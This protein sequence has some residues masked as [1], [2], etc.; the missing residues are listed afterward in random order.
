MRAQ[1]LWL[2][3]RCNRAACLVAAAAIHVAHVALGLPEGLEQ[4]LL[5]HAATSED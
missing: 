3:L 4:A 1:A 2:L 5:A